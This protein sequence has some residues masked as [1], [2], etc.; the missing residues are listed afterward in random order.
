MIVGDV[1]GCLRELDELIERL[2]PSQGDK[3]HFLGDLVDRG[4]DSLGVVRRV[5]G[6]LEEFPGSVCVAGNH[7]DKVLRYRESGR[8]LPPWANDADADD[9]AFL[10]GL[11]LIH[12]LPEHDAIM[13]HGG[14]FPAFFEAYG[15][16]G[17]M[18][19]DWRTAKGKRADRMRR[20]LRIR[21]VNSA[22]NMISLYQ[23]TAADRRWAELYDGRE[24]FAFYGHYAV[25]DPPEPLVDEHAMNLDTGCCFGGRLT[26]V[27]LSESM[28]AEAAEIVSITARARYSEFLENEAG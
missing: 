18:P 17:E 19:A 23:A 10:E 8:P 12:R 15:E 1:H 26:A 24:G 16:L 21:K 28:P 9:W 22:G 27:I 4:P 6:L 3:V 2:A 11:P 7:E 20:F 5:R 14:F 13:V 25:I